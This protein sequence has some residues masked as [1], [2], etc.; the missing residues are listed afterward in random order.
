MATTD[1]LL[2][3]DGV[4]GESTQHDGWIDIESFS[5]GVTNAG[6]FGMGGGGGAGKST[7]QDIHFAKYVDKASP[8]LAQNC[9]SGKHIAKAILHVRKAGENQ[10]EY[11]TVTLE[12]VLVSSFQ[13]GGG[14]GDPRVTDQFSPARML[15]P[16]ERVMLLP[17]SSC[18]RLP[19]V[20]RPVLATKSQVT[21]EDRVMLRVACSVIWEKPR[22]AEFTS[23]FSV[24]A[25][26]ASPEPTVPGP[27][28]PEPLLPMTISNGSINSRPP[29]LR[30]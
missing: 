10:K 28:L 16:L 25:M 1:F 21:P 2:E 3:L 17:A 26:G 8:V 29:A 7:F 23:R 30:A 19:G 13:A 27:A 22:N 11:Y 14:S 24:P 12:D 15:E 6:S 4:K 18:K 5:W 20:L 9:A